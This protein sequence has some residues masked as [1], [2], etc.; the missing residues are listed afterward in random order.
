VAHTD[1]TPVQV[2][3]IACHLI[4]G[5]AVYARLKAAERRVL[6]TSELVTAY[7]PLGDAPAEL[8]AAI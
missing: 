3:V 8:I 4:E 7:A 2:V 1:I 6:V 5:D